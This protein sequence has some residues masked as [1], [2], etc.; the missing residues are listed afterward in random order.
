MTSSL[1][2]SEMCIRDSPISP[3]LECW[4]AELEHWK[5]TSI[6]PVHHPL[7][8]SLHLAGMWAPWVNAMDCEI[9]AN[10]GQEMQYRDHAGIP[11]IVLKKV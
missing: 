10:T 1:V 5:Q 2:G 9:A 11:K 3:V 6:E 8:A 7:T 4:S